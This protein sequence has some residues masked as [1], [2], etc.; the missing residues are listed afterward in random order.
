MRVGLVVGEGL[1]LEAVSRRLEGP[2]MVKKEAEN[3]KPLNGG[4]CT[5]TGSPS[6]IENPNVPS[7]AETVCSTCPL[8]RT[9][10]I[11]TPGKGHRALPVFAN[12]VEPKIV[13]PVLSVIVRDAEPMA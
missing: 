9:S 11:G 4:M 6:A 10:S 7:A 1:S 5:W 12:K 3:S 13:V 2:L 8:S